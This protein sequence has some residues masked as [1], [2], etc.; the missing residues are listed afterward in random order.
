MLPV[1]KVRG[2]F[3]NRALEPIDREILIGAYRVDAERRRAAQ[4]E[5]ERRP[6]RGA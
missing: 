1:E 2:W 3:E 6:P 5:R 4:A